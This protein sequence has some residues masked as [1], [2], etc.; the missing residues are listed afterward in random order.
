MRT[1]LEWIRSMVPELSC[2][3]QEY[4]DAMT[5]SGSKVEGYEELDADLEKIVIGQIEKIEKHPDAD[6]LIICQVNVGTGE[7][8]QIVTGAPNVKEGDKV[9]VV[10]DGGRVAGGHDGKKTPGGVKIKKGK[11]RGVESFGMMCSIEELGSTKDMYPE[12]P[13]YGIYI[14]AEDAVVGAD[15]VEA[16]GLHNSVFEYEITSNRVDCFGI[17][18]LAREAAATFRKEFHPPVVT[19]TGNN[20]D[21]NDYV[22]VSVED[23]KL[24]PRYT[25][26]VVKNIKIAPSPEWMQRRLAAQG[27][28]PINNIVDI[29]NYVMEEYGQPMHAYDLDT[30]AGHQIVV[31]RAEK[32]QKFVT[33]D[34]Q[35]RTMD[36]SVLMICDGEK[37]IGIAG[38]MGGE[39]SMITDDVK[40]MLF[41]AACFDGTNIRLSSKKVGLRTD[42]SGKFEKGLDPNNAIEAMNRACQLIEELGAGEV[43]GGVVDVYTTVKEGRNI[44]FEPEKYNR[45]LGTDIAPETMLDYF[46]MLDLGYDKEK[47]EIL[48]PSWRQ[49]LECDA[50]IAEEVARF[51][52]Y[53]KIPTS[54]PSGEATTGKLSFKLR[55]EKLARDIAEFCGFSQAMTYS[56]ESPKVF[57]KLLLPAD[58]PLR[59]TVV[60]TNP[61]GEDFSIMRTVSLNGMLASLAT[62]YN[63]RNQ[64]VRLYELGNIYL[65]KQTPVTELPEERMQFTLGMYGE[66]DFYTMKGV[67]EE[68]FDKLGMH[69]KAEYDPSDK[70]SFLH[71]GRQA[72]IIYNGNVI[73][74]LGEIHPTVAANYAIKERVYVAVLDMPYVVEYASFDRKYRGIAKFPAVTRDLSMVVPKEVLAGDIEKVFDEKGGQYLERYALFDIYEGAQIKRGYKSIAYTLTFR[75]QDKTLEDADIQNAMNKILKKLEELGIELR[76]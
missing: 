39:N 45:L 73:G 32:G 76:K 51:Y 38:I 44:P 26:R 47:N 70:K 33:L 72:D 37:A 16:L 17:I 28:R 48:V 25:A 69:E 46:K 41:E 49:D 74:Y 43:V 4:M 68:L 71:P 65:P 36:D 50:D 29:T 61:L 64:N 34:G 21:V 62:N 19:A 52:G 23:T 35:E 13:E 7:N 15:A 57:D 24:C 11:L 66:G 20:E 9:P 63:R 58:S 67:V 40:T 30:I 1:S 3:A 27:I 59:E 14:F 18:G 6:K 55:V 5:L 12:A 2:T 54:L 60:I 31:K 75:A 56:F 22:K 53:D 8:I 10:L 42:A